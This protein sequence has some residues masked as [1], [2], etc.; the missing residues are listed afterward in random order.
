[1][2]NSFVDL[3]PVFAWLFATIQI[4]GLTSAWIARTGAGSKRHAACQWLFFGCLAL[5]AAAAVLSIPLASGTWII[6][7][8]TLSLMIV[9]TTFDAGL[10]QR[11]R[12]I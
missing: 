10:Q 5:V 12:A 8:V 7:G 3:Q 1:M 2:F 9:G 11:G 4:V 6:S